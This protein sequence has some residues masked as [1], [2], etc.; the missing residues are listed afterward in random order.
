M[1]RRCFTEINKKMG[2]YIRIKKAEVVPDQFGQHIAIKMVGLYE[3]DPETGQEKYIR[4]T[5]LTPELIELLCKT[6]IPLK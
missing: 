2:K 6:N 5:K 3:T 1:D 4:W